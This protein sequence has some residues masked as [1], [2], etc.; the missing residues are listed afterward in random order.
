[1]F[2]KDHESCRQN[3]A[4]VSG[5]VRCNTSLF[6]NQTGHDNR[7]LHEITRDY[8]VSQGI[9]RGYNGLQGITKGYKRLQ[10]IT[11]SYRGLKGVIGD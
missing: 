3:K 5:S 9:G 8:S 7:G 10:G 4:I 11:R 6:T 2:V 1:M